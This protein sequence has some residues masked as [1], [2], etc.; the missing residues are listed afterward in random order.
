MSEVTIRPATDDD[1]VAMTVV[2]ARAFG[3]VWKDEDRELFRPNLELDRFRL[4]M[5]G[6]D[7]VG[8]AGSYGMEL[9]VPGGAQVR[10]G[11]VTWVAVAVTHRRRGLLRR[12]IGEIHDDIATRGEPLAMLTASEAGIYERFGYGVATS[13]RVVEIDRRRTALADRH[14]SDDRIRIATPRDHLEEIHA[15]YDRYRRSRVGAVNRSMNWVRVRVHDHGEGATL[16]LHPDGFAIWKVTEDWNDGFPAHR[17]ELFDLIACT[18]ESHAALWNAVLSIDLA[19]PIRSTGAVAEDDPLPYLLNDPRQLRTTNL[20]DMLWIRPMDVPAVLSA[21]TYG[22][23]DRLVVELA[24]DGAPGGG[25]RW[26]IDGAPDG[27]AVRKVRSRPDLVTDRAS[28]G[29]MYLGGVR[30]SLLAA[31]RRLEARS[32]EALRRADHFFSSLQ[33]PHCNTGF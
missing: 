32:D 33:R 11:G 1:F 8:V 12:L 23:D 15:V 16:A 29:A 9:T 21:R 19:G 28:L 13:W 24:D 26:R 25:T 27:A 18:P 10:A 17:V 4:A 31:G 3:D 20:N 22:T 6:D 30:P 2:D 5:D 14:R 7:I